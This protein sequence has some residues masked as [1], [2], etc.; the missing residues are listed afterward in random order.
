[1]RN[2][3]SYLHLSWESERKPKGQI[4]GEV[5][6]HGNLENMNKTELDMKKIHKSMN[7]ADPIKNR[8]GTQV[9]WKGKQFLLLRRHSK[10]CSF[11]NSA[12]VISGLRGSF[13]GITTSGWNKRTAFYGLLRNSQVNVRVNLW[14]RYSKPAKTIVVSNNICKITDC[15]I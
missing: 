13:N 15:L 8:G 14:N 11:S 7:N 10:H 1:M 12:L 5:D 3:L 4:K 9:V 6:R 2:M